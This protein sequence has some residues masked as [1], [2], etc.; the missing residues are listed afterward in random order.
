M[1]SSLIGFRGA[2]VALALIL[3]LAATRVDAACDNIVA[4]SLGWAEYMALDPATLSTRRVGDLRWLG[5]HS[6]NFV[7]EGS[8]F[9][10]SVLN[11]YDYLRVNS[12]QPVIEGHPSS[13][14]ASAFTLLSLNDMGE[15]LRTQD[16]IPIMDSG[17]IMIESENRIQWADWIEMNTLIREI[18]DRDQHYY[19]GY[20]LLDT[21]FNVLRR[22]EPEVGFNFPWPTCAMDESIFFAGRRGV[23]SFDDQNGT[24]FELDILRNKGLRLAT[25]HTKNCKALAFRDTPDDNPMRG[26]ALV[27]VVEGT[28]GPEFAAQK[29][30]EY[31]L[32]DDGRRLLQQVIGV[33]YRRDSIGRI[34]EFHSTPTD[35]FNLIDTTT[36][37][38]L[39]ER[40]LGTGSGLLSGE[41]LCDKETPRALVRDN[42]TI[43][44]IDPNNLEITASRTMPEGW[45]GGYVIF[46]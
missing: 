32:Y 36:G 15:D 21:N 22:W 28:L 8:D 18:Y 33:D 38:V 27:D 5:V 42:N 24:I 43:Y 37:Q 7:A 16:E 11:S 6:V 3:P 35:Q 45:G 46:E 4:V 31:L 2:G 20:E 30:S 29:Y 39:L 1:L 13:R 44:L 14:T 41:M 40:E 19:S 25:S 10:R 12:E 34:V 17:D 23:H 9:E 26:V